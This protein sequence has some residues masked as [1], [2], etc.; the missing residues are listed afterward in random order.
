LLA[1]IRAY[2]LLLAW[3]ALQLV[4]G[5]GGLLEPSSG[6]GVAYWAHIG[7]F[8]FGAIVAAAWLWVKPVS[9]VCYVPLSCSCTCAGGKCTKKHNHRWEVLKFWKAKVKECDGRPGH[10]HENK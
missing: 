1:I 9:S 4:P 8:L 2:W 6:G 7:G 5:I 10:E 3:F